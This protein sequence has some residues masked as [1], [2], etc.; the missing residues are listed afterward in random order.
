[1]GTYRSRRHTI[2]TLLALDGDIGAAGSFELDFEVAC[3][4]QV[5]STTLLAFSSVRLTLAD[6]VEVLIDEL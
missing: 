1:M 5:S 3:A 6:V 2:E 4:L